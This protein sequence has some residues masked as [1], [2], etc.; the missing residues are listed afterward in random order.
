[1]S[2]SFQNPATFTGPASQAMRVG[3]TGATGGLGR[4]VVAHLR[5]RGHEVHALV[6]KRREELEGVHQH[7]GDLGDRAALA[8]FAEG[9]DACLHLAAQ[10]E[11]AEWE[12]YQRVNVQG[13]WLLCQALL[14]HAPRCRLVHVSTLS[15][16]GADS[17]W[18]TDYARS[19]RDGEAVVAHYQRQGLSTVIVRPGLIYGPH[20]TKVVPT[21]VRFLKGP[22]AFLVSGGEAQAP[23]VYTE[24]LCE[25]LERAA[26][27]ERAHGKTYLAVSGQREGMEDLLR[28]LAWRT[29]AP[30]PTRKYPRGALYALVLLLES[31][32]RLR[33]VGRRP[34]LSRR[35]VHVLSLRAP[36]S[37]EQARDELGWRPR[38]S[39]AET[40]DATF[41]WYRAQD[42]Q[43]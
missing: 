33:V 24:D 15:V 27:A 19:K 11:S 2:V 3:L 4:A 38:Q 39:L 35:L 21:L 30:L 10:V 6:R 40:L 29:G 20:D 18:A 14:E 26:C 36:G 41:A 34:A 42:I 1:M 43:L 12:T 13:T 7:V 37:P 23:L 5:S 25:L 22:H 16:L 8:A 31:L 28:E 17:R 32:H 9:L